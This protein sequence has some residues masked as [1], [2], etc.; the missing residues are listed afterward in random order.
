MMQMQTDVGKAFG[1][2]LIRSDEMDSAIKLWDEIST[3]RPP[4]IDP[5][6]GVYTINMAKHIADTR[7][8]LIMLDIGITVSNGTDQKNPRA[9]WL[10]ARADE[11][12][13]RLPEK[14]PDAVRLGGIIIKF[15]GANW[16]YILPNNFGITKVDGNGEIMGAV[17]AEHYAEGK[18]HFTRLEYH[19]FDDDGIYHVL[20]K[21]FRN[22]SVSSGV[23]SLGSEVPLEKVSV[24]AKME[25]EVQ[26]QDLEKPLFAYF[27]MT[28]SN[29]IDPLSPLGVSVFANALTELKS[30]DVAISR[31]DSE[32]VDSKHITFVGQA[33][34][35]Y[36]DNRKI[37]LPRFITGIGMG[38]D[39]TSTNAIR[40]HNPTIQTDA[41]LKDINFNL[42][43]CG[44]KCGFSEGVFT[45]DGQHG[46]VTATQV[47]ADDRDTIQ[48]VKADRDALQ[49]AIDQ[50]LYGASALADLMRLAP[51]G[52][53]DVHYSFGDITYSY[54]EDKANWRSYVLQGWV[55]V[56]MY[57]VKFEKMSEDEARAMAEEMKQE[58]FNNLM[59]QQQLEA[60]ANPPAPDIQDEQP[61]NPEE[62]ELV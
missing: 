53:Y 57:F 52:D 62:P 11:L 23:L 8:R 58:S 30:V 51:A 45:L 60:A 10:Q 7:A 25:P 44:V 49:S 6:D 33:I 34:K 29:T 48:T 38:V 19:Y 4:W 42:S 24:W 2:D 17:F 22:N 56:W 31:K 32:I 3:G 61:E 13:K 14:M 50:A 39:D 36:A 20:N 47:E 54:E 1:V 26:I 46:V 9:E 21:A 12:M 16:D 5:E 18:A 41:R 40:E 28:G 35:Q 27:R 59:L 37:K 43:M 15:N 55:P